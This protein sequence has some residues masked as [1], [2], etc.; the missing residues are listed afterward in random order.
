MSGSRPRG[1]RLDDPLRARRRWLQHAGMG[2]GAIA[3]DW[4]RSSGAAATPPDTPPR[5]AGILQEAH[6]AP[7]AKRVIWLYMDGGLSHL[8]SFDPKPTLAKLHGQPF[9]LTIE[10]TQFD[11]NGPILQSPWSFQSHGQSGLPVSELFPHIAKHVDELAFIRSMTSESSVHANANYWMNTGW[12]LMGRPSVGAWISYALGT[13]NANL[14]AFVVLNSGLMPT[15]GFASF[16][17][18]FLPASHMASRL[19]LGAVP[20]ANIQPAD[21]ATQQRQLDYIAAMDRDFAD[22]LGGNDAITSS[23]RNYELA[24]RL[25]TAVPDLLDLQGES[26]ATLDAYGFSHLN[27]H[28][29]T[30]ARQCLLARRMMERDVRFVAV[31]MPK[32]VGENRWDAHGDLKGNHESN[33]MTVDQPIAA[34][35]TDLKQR[36]LWDDTLV[37]FVTEF[38]RTPFSQGSDGR[39]HNP[40]GFT[41]WMAGGGVRGGTTFGTTDEFGYKVVEN[42]LLIH[43]LHATVL[44]LLGVDHERLTYRHGG[45]DYR[46]TDVHGHVIE[47]ILT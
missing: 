45:R 23:I 34:L 24:A 5:A 30:Y 1:N 29:R 19:E 18:G 27:E 9:P 35:L 31:T 38:G 47:S 14:P 40:F 44:H 16:Q 42:K 22:Q 17:S 43:D 13:E 32:V 46:L 26:Q 37:C 39:D 33:A 36:G 28:T 12:G 10:A 2:V 25:Q 11:S 20:M 7:R 6:V 4:L 15:G 8:D 21:A 41:I 3:L